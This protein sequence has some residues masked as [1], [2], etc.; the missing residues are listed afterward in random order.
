MEEVSGPVIAIGLILSAVFVPVGFMGGITGRFYQQ[1]AITIALSVLLSVI[2]ALTLSPALSA[3]LLRAPTGKK[4]LLTPF[5]TWFNKVFGRGTEKYV[6]FSG[7]LI[8]KTARSLIFIGILVVAIVVLVRHIPAG[9]IPEEDQ[10]YLLV[11]ANLPDAASLERTDLVMRKAEAIIKANESVEGY[12]TVTG[13]S[14]ITGAYSSNQGFFFIQLK[15][16]SDRKSAAEHANGVI[17]ALNREFVQQIPEAVL[18][19]FGPPAIPGLGTGAGFTMQL[20]D[21]RGGSPEYLAQQAAR[22][23][24]AARKRPEIGRISTLYRANVPQVFADV[25]RSKVLKVGATITDVNTTLGALLGSS[26]VNDFNRFGRVYKV[27]VQA[28][29]E[30]RRDPKQL[31][32]FFVRSAQGQMIP[33]DT[34]ITTRPTSGPEYTN[35][36]NLY[37][38]AEISGVPA[39]GYSSAQALTALEETAKEVLPPEMGYEWADMSYQEKRAPGVAGVFS[40]AILLVFLILAAQY[41]SWGLP[42]SVLLGTPFAVFG[43]YFGLWL[44]RQFS[45]SYV[46]NVFAQIALIMLIGLAAKNA[47]LIVEF[48]KMLHEQGKGLVEAA[49]EAAKLRFRPILMTAFA[50]ILGV[51]PLLT[52][53]GAGAEARKVMGMAVFAGMLIATILGVCLIPVLFVTVEKLSGRGKHPAPPGGAAPADAHGAGGH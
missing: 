30:Y 33:L 42:F 39:S 35:R 20:Q 31:G 13:F 34:V 21:R 3:L 53:S 5:Y 9:F 52:A 27:Y 19:A 50:F 12:N 24:E 16:W 15:E 6:S 44:A 43:A 28:E 4:T 48:A 23:I 36:F 17:A 45:E 32:L 47:I 1:F 40:I 22:F 8:R 51:V 37:R 25:D 41:E 10:G 7:I 29:A 18:V 38:S 49:L 26:Y 14:L 46:N 2:N 11:Q